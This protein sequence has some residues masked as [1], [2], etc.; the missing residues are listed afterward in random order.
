MAIEL[1]VPI[2]V[3][4]EKGNWKVIKVDG[5]VLPVHY[6]GDAPDDWWGLSWRDTGLC[7]CDYCNEPVPLIVFRMW[8]TIGSK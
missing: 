2:K 1:Q 4:F 6:H 3:L 8:E 7:H 5:V